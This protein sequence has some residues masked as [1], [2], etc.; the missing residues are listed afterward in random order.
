MAAIIISGM[1]RSGT[2]AVAQY[3]RSCGLYVGDDLIKGSVNN[4]RGY[5]ESRRI[6]G[7]HDN[8]LK[9]YGITWR[10]ETGN[11]AFRFT[12]EEIAEAREFITDIPGGRAWGWKDP[13][14]TLFLESWDRILPEARYLL[15]HRD[16]GEVIYSLWRRGD[17]CSVVPVIGKRVKDPVA[18]LKIW[19]EY[20]RRLLEFYTKNRER[21]VLISCRAFFSDL[22]GSVEKINT[23]FSVALKE[24]ES[25][26]EEQLMKTNVPFYFRFLTR[27]PVTVKIQERLQ[28]LSCDPE[29]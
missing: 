12:D 23:Q 20:N 15:I 17:V 6:V 29:T 21:C 19:N 3:M 8:V 11:C 24:Q 18:I 1:H 16:P 10:L 4:R 22:P 9:R 27:N 2:S 5:F 14:T 13:R 26:F 25:T 28:R 7:F